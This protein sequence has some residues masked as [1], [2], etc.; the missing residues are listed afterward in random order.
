[1]E[2][3]GGGREEERKKEYMIKNQINHSGQGSS[4]VSVRGSIVNTLSFA[5]HTISM[6][7]AHLC[8]DPLYVKY[9]NIHEVFII[10]PRCNNWLI[11]SATS[12]YIQSKLWNIKGEE[13]KI[14]RVLRQK[15]F[16]RVGE[17]R[18][19]SCLFHKNI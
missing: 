15:K 5:S 16:P 8:C 11:L 14:I 12:S 13:K 2:G 7:A 1:M 4:D 6:T 18:L 10:E 19:A 3:E 17:I 9:I